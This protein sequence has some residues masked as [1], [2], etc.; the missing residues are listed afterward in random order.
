MVKTYSA[1]TIGRNKIV[2]KVFIPNRGVCAVRLLKTLKRLGIPAVVAFTP[3]DEDCFHVKFAKE[4]AEVIAYDD[5]SSIMKAASLCGADAILPGWGFKSEDPKLAKACQKVGITFIGPAEDVMK[6][7]GKKELTKDLAVK[8]CVPIIPGT[9]KS[10][11]KGGLEK[12]AIANGLSNEEDSV[13]FMLKATA[14]GGGNGNEIISCLSEMNAALDRIGGRAKRYW[15]SRKLLLEL[16]IENA[17]HIEVQFVRDQ[18]E[19]FLDLGTRECSLQVRYQKLIEISPAWMLT[20]G[21]EEALSRYT[22][23]LAELVNYCGV[24]TVEFL[25]TEKGEI[26]FLEIN[27]RLQVEHGI[28]ELITAIDLVEMQILIAQGKELSISQEDVIFDGSAVEVRV[29]TQ[30]RDPQNLKT[31]IGVAGIVEELKLPKI[32]HVRLEHALSIGEE[33]GPNFNSTQMQAMAWAPTREK[34]LSKLKGALEKME[35]G[36]GNNIS[37]LCEILEHPKVKEGDYGIDFLEEFLKDS[38]KKFNE[39]EVAAAVAVALAT[40]LGNKQS[41]P[42]VPPQSYWR[43]AGRHAQLNSFPGGRGW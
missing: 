14:G 16:Y 32:K 20:Q 25:L 41:Y 36:I 24:G 10:M 28:T 42:K 21:Q 5:V 22:K 1:L 12:W 4:S 23:D 9:P 39:K 43:L 3:E 18:H 38:A 17:R 2:T 11:K 7:C 19:N 30:I 27:P 15:D 8:A 26:Y 29:N 35:I 31:L 37:F 40:A 6:V 13:T 34:A 33:I